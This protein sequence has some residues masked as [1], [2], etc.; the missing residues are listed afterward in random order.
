MNDDAKKMLWWGI[1]VV[2]AAGLIAALYYGRKQR[3]EAP[4]TQ[5]ASQAPMTTAPAQAADHPIEPPASDAPALPGLA[6]SDAALKDSISGVF[7]RSLDQ[8][9]V[10][11][12]IVRHIVATID[13][14]PRKKVA[15]QMWPL[16]PTGGAPAVDMQG[17]TVTLSKDNSARYAPIM[18]V[19]RNT[20]TRQLVAVYKH[21]YPLF[22]Q[23]YTDLGYP[24]GYF[25][26]RLVEVIDHLLATPE[27]KGPIQLT[28]PGVFYQFADPA[29]EERSAG[30]KLLI[31]MGSE[32]AAELKLK[33]RE[34]RREITRA[35]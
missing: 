6:Q 22:Q 18:A 16:V 31:R 24:D 23:A 8:F 25:N 19:V 17:D 35:N 29:L 28:Q 9:L 32:N 34:V 21:F 27:I 2:V 1:P 33:L 15:V 7:G 12:D 5:E 13:N 11:K 30:Q 14:L 26:N 3:E 4:V 20:D 10:P